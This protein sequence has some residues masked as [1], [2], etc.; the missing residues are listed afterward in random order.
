MWGTRM[1]DRLAKLSSSIAHCGM[2]WEVRVWS[3][4]RDEQEA[5]DPEV[6]NFEAAAVAG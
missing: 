6:R 2:D 1:A 5:S 4:E 3:A